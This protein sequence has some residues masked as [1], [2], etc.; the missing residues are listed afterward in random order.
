MPKKKTGIATDGMMSLPFS[1]STVGDEVELNMEG[2][3]SL[4]KVCGTIGRKTDK[5]LQKLR[6]Q[7]NDILKL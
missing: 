1:V 4:S 3:A 5:T 6:P 2:S 7:V